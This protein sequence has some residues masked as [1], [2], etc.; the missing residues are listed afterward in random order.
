MRYRYSRIRKG[1]SGKRV[2]ESILLPTPPLNINDTHVEVGIHDRLDL[3]A[4]KYYNNK[5]LW[6]VI[7]AANNVGKGTMYFTQ[8][9]IIRI[10]AN[11]SSIAQSLRFTGK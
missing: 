8:G 11:P 1:T 10:P 6:W 5:N 4:Q 7:A 2:R 3:L 9:T